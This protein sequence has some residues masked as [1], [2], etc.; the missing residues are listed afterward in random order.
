MPEHCKNQTKQKHFE[1]LVI[2]FCSSHD[3]LREFKNN[4]NNADS[5]PHSKYRI[6]SNGF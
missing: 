6:E 1:C 5:L 3:S 4:N 2:F